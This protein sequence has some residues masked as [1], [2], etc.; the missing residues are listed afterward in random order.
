MVSARVGGGAHTD[1]ASPICRSPVAT[2]HQERG[3]SKDEGN[4]NSVGWDRMRPSQGEGGKW[5]V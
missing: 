5:R 3:N 2:R 4:F 1:G